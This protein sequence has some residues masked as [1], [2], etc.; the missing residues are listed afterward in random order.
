MC[1]LLNTSGYAAGEVSGRKT[2][3]DGRGPAEEELLSLY[4]RMKDRV[5]VCAERVTGKHKEKL[6]CHSQKA[7]GLC[8]W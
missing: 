7:R 1:H 5:L 3:K 6:W 4:R 8:L 2:P